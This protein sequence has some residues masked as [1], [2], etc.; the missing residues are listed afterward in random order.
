MS[1]KLTTGEVA[2]MARVSSQS[3]RRWADE[4][5]IEFETTPLGKLFLRE[6]VERFIAERA[7]RGEK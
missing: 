6:S 4:G 1:E 2:L 5:R 7:A 3:V